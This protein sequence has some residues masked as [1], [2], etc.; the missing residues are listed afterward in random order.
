MLCSEAGDVAVNDLTACKEAAKALSLDFE[1]TK[2]LA[3]Y[4]KG[5]YS[6]GVVYFN[7][8]VHGSRNSYAR[9]ICKPGGKKLRYFPTSMQLL[10]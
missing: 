6:R 5:C 7:R 10:V 3:H 9:Q 1:R 4:P 8:H 2:D